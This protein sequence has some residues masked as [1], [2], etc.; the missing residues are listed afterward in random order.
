MFV[1][2]YNIVRNQF[3]WSILLCLENFNQIIKPKF[4]VGDRLAIARYKFIF[5]K[6]YT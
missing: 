1:D 4:S 2:E 3:M 6:G 5:S